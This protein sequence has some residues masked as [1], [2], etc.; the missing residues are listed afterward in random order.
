M[1]DRILP[2]PA[3]TTADTVDL[4]NVVRTL[5]RGWRAVIA[6]TLLGA[7]AAVA[8]V[9]FA[10]PKFTG[11]A[12]IVLKSGSEG[13]ASSVLSQLTGL[14]GAAQGILGGAV[15]SPVETELEVLNSRE[16]AGRVIDSLGLQ[17]RV[18][19]PRSIAPGAIVSNVHL[20]SAFK[21]ARFAFTRQGN[22]YRVTGADNFTAT[23]PAGAPVTLPVG[24]IELA[25]TA[26]ASFTLDLMDHEDAI[27]RLQKS[28]NAAKSAGEV[29]RITYKGDDSLTAAAV[30][31]ALIAEYLA[32]RKTTDRGVNERRVEYLS[33]TMDSVNRQLAD[34]EHQLKLVRQSS[35]VFDPQANGKADF[36]EAAALRERLTELEV[37]QGALSAL[38][39]QAAAGTISPRQLAAFPTFL[40]SPGINSLIGQLSEVDSKRF[41]LLGTRTPNDPEVQALAQSAKNLEGQLLP[42]A[43]AY[44]TSVTTQRSDVQA[45]LDTIDATL[46]ALPSAAEANIRLQRQVLQLGTIYGGMQAQLVDARLAAIGEGGEAEPLDLATPPKKPSFPRPLVTL[47]A[48]IAGGLFCGMVAALLVG[49]LGGWLQD[50]ESVERVVGVPTLRFDPTVPLLVGGTGAR[51][52]L[53]APVNAG[54]AVDPVIERLVATATRRSIATGV[55]DLSS[56]SVAHVDEAIARLEAENGLVVVKL[57]AITTDTA[58]AA[59]RADR[60]V[61]LVT[62]E[63]RV[64]RTQLVSAMQLLRRLDVP[65]AGVVMGSTAPNGVA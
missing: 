10:P 12:S 33:A 5:R 6:F 45:Q 24:T 62:P 58:A 16:L 28:L 20:A 11:S 60:P 48:G 39:S 8:V 63:R 42:L 25:P 43:R 64:A 55:L 44:A 52:V 34:A 38:I 54:I 29:A 35:H 40:K 65:C 3:D 7:V 30:P 4:A 50:P 37:E 1:T 32:R 15:K 36:D 14:G 41:E 18:I 53:V 9:L 13:G 46:A 56:G 27:A 47:G 51:T 19:T 21:K 61:L 17:A 31:N 23:A 26:P 57:P 59:V 2:A 49:A 22:S